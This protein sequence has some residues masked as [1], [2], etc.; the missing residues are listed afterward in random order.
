MGCQ[1]YFEVK[2]PLQ[3]QEFSEAMIKFRRYQL[4]RDIEES[5]YPSELGQLV[6]VIVI[7]NLVGQGAE[8]ETS[9]L[10]KKVSEQVQFMTFRILWKSKQCTL[11]CPALVPIAALL[12]HMFNEKIGHH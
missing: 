7:C 12:W 4:K 5:I 3:K 6:T 9:R 1:Q 11:Y 8:F 10:L 2:T